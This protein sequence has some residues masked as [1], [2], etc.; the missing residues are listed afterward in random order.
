MIDALHGIRTP[1]LISPKTIF[2]DFLAPLCSTPSRAHAAISS[3]PVG[4]YITFWV[5]SGVPMTLL[6]VEMYF[7]CFVF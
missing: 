4:N 1:T 6:C 7:I 2:I 5:I 3:L